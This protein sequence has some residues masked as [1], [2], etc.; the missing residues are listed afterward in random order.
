MREPVVGHEL[1]PERRQH[2]EERRLLVVAL[3]LFCATSQ[4]VTFTTFVR[5]RLRAREQ[6]PADHLR[7]WLQQ[8]YSISMAILRQLIQ[9]QIGKR[10]V[11]LHVPRKEL[12]RRSHLRIAD[13]VTDAGQVTEANQLSPADLRLVATD[14]FEVGM[15]LR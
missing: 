13:V 14:R 7:V 4:A 2:I 3:G 9:T 5:L 15:A 11:E 12:I 6:L 1:D 10:G 8:P